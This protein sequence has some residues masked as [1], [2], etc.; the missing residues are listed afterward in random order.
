MAFKVSTQGNRK[1]ARL[2]EMVNADQELVQ[3]WECAN[4][5]ATERAGISDHGPVHIQIVA[6]ACVK[7]LRLLRDSGVAP[8]I[9][10]DYGLAYEDAEIV[11]VLAACLHDIGIAVH[12]DNHESYSLNLAYPKSRQLLA[13]LYEEPALTKVVAEVLHAVI[14]HRWDVT[15]LS[16]EAGVLKV[17]DALDM[18][19][20]RSRIPFESGEINIHSVSAQAVESVTIERGEERPIRLNIQL[21]NSAGIFQVDELLRRKLTNSTLKPYVEVVAH[22]GEEA[23]RHLLEIY[24]L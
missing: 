11:V 15:C 1:L 23:E 9:V 17:A 24:R 4:I 7:L 20:G 18:T 12:R 8:S 2:L 16:L 3:L 21:N 10:N 5:T 19:E 22:M 13:G 14:A 6:N